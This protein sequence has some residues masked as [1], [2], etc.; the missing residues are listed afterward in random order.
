MIAKSFV[1]RTLDDGRLER[2][3]TICEVPVVTYRMPSAGSDG[4]AVARFYDDL[5]DKVQ[6]HIS[7]HTLGDALTRIQALRQSLS[8]ATT[9]ITELR[10]VR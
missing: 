4:L 1:L 9:A 7:G 10:S 2:V 6:R 5:S 3:C 8:E